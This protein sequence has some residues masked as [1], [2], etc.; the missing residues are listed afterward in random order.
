M[1]ATHNNKKLYIPYPHKKKTKGV[2]MEESFL[3]K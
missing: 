2:S 3:Q 1:L